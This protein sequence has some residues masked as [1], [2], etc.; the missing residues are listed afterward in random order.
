MAAASPDL[1][2]RLPGCAPGALT[3][4]DLRAVLDACAAFAGQGVTVLAASPDEPRYGCAAEATQRAERA[5]RAVGERLDP[6]GEKPP[7]AA[8]LRRLR[9]LSEIARRHET[10]I[11]IAP[12]DA[13]PPWISVAP[14]T[15]GACAERFTVTGRTCIAG[16]VLEIGGETTARVLLR[17]EPGNELVSGTVALNEATRL[18]QHLY[19][20]AVVDAEVTWVRGS[21]RIL[22]LHVERVVPYRRRSLAEARE[23]VRS[24][25]ADRWDGLRDPAPGAAAGAAGG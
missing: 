16:E 19:S 13:D 15:Y 18:A 21:W 23:M 2:I 9:A 6:A 17:A 7:R 24:M 10:R 8:D 3:A 1:D 20:R 12:R 14:G 11:E 22:D 25:G 4:D 5:L